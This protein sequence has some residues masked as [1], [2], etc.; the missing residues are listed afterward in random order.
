VGQFILKRGGNRRDR[1]FGEN[2]AA[3]VLVMGIVLIFFSVPRFR[4]PGC[5]V[6]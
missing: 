2:A 1:G 5:A 3:G 6:T 4:I